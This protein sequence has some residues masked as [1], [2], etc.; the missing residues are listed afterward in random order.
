S[1]GSH[2]I[3]RLIAGGCA[4]SYLNHAFATSKSFWMGSGYSPAS[5]SLTVGI[6]SAPLR[7]PRIP[8]GRPVDQPAAGP[9]VDRAV[10]PHRSGARQ[11]LD[12]PRDLVGRQP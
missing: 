2:A 8:G 9:A 5:R 7:A 3:T 12:R 10:G 4:K 1:S 6:G 11:G